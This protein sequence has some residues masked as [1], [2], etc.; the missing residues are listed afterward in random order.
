[1]KCGKCSLVI[2]RRLGT[3]IKGEHIVFFKP[4]TPKNRI[5]NNRIDKVI[6][7]AEPIQVKI[8]AKL[9]I[10]GRGEYYQAIKV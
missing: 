8:V 1:M 10:K 6:G 2:D 7:K 4:E 9:S 3:N 5:K